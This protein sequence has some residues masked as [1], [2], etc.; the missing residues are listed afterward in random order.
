V[1]EVTESTENGQKS[2]GI[3]RVKPDGERRPG[4]VSTGF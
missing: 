2:S 1:Q 4:D 3:R